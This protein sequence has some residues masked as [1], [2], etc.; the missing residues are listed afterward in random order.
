M[1]IGRHHHGRALAAVV[2][3]LGFD[4]AIAQGQ[5]RSKYEGAARQPERRTAVDVPEAA[6]MDLTA[7]AGDWI[8]GTWRSNTD[9]NFVLTFMADGSYTYSHRN[10]RLQQIAEHSGTWLIA[11]SPRPSESTADAIR[12]G[13]GAWPAVDGIVGRRAEGAGLI[14]NLRPQR[15]GVYSSAPPI[16]LGND[17]A[18]F[19][20]AFRI[21]PG[22]QR[23]ERM[24]MLN[25]DQGPADQFGQMRFTREL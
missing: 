7:R 13:S 10:R 14:V 24:R 5:P 15:I 20:I 25:L 6:P 11:L 4:V 12:A 1:R 23:P 9:G 18:S 22:G 19:R 17:P 8:V 16:Y 2:I 21:E 3:V